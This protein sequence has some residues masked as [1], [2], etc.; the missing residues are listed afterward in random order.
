MDFIVKQSDNRISVYDT[1]LF[2]IDSDNDIFGDFE[3]HSESQGEG[4][5]GKERFIETHPAPIHDIDIEYIRQKHD[6]SP[7]RFFL[8]GSRH[9]YKTSDMVIGGVVYPVV[10]GQIIVGCCSRQDREICNFSFKRKIV[11]A[12]PKAFDY[13]NLGDN[14]LRKRRTEIN[15]ALKEKHGESVIQLDRIVCYQTDGN[16]EEGRN[17]YLHQAI[18]VVQ[19]EMMDQ[20]QRLVGEL[21]SNPANIINH[22]SWLVKDGTLEYRR[23]FTN[24]PNENLDIAQY[25]H[26]LKYV[27]GVSKEFNQELLS[28]VEPKIGR[29]ISELKPFQRTNAY[30][31]KHQNKTYCV[32]YLRIRNTPNRETRISDVIKVEF[33]VANNAPVDSNLIDNISAHLINE[34]YPVCFGKDSRWAK[35]IY[36]I[37][38]TEAYCKSKYLNENKIIRLI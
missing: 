29:I 34:A 6:K 24:R 21:C 1:Q 32:W 15:Q 18:A 7:L 11:L 30:R 35:H 5:K 37:Y 16:I 20:E 28:E 19:N 26:K 23:E 22:T 8:D 9:V 33:L 10:V 13:D 38:L 4:S 25:T 14:F 3:D 27:I 17:K 36:P 12:V 2:R 31:Y